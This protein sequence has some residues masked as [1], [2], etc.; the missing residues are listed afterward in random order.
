[1]SIFLFTAENTERTELRKRSSQIIVAF[2][3]RAELLHSEVIWV[4]CAT[5]R[6]KLINIGD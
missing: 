2:G 5:D 6:P 3:V 1:M 4:R